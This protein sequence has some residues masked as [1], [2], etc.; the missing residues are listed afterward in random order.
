MKRSRLVPQRI[1]LG[2]AAFDA[3]VAL[4]ERALGELRENEK[5]SRGADF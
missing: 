3:A 5:L 4:H 1:V 2:D